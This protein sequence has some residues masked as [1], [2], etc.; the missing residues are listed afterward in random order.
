M[1]CTEMQTCPELEKLP[2]SSP[3][4]ALS[5]SASSATMTPELLPSSRITR[6]RPALARMPRP[7]A[8]LPVKLTSC[9]RGSVTRASPT[10]LPAPVTMFTAPAGTPASS[11]SRPKCSAV[12]GVGVGGLTTRVLPAARAGATL[13]ASRLS[14]KLNGEMA[15]TGPRGTRNQKPMRRSD[16][17]IASR[18]T[19][20][21]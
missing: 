9:M 6:L 5:R 16:P 21:P 17:G 11:K 7:T 13:C 12:S 18:G 4:K 10:T 15:A 2:V 19:V 20:S 1:R 8:G 3:G 14:G